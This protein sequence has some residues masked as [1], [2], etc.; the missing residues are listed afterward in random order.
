[1]DGLSYLV[2]TYVVSRTFTMALRAQRLVNLI[3]AETNDAMVW[4]MTP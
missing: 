4:V 3:Y 1:M 2:E